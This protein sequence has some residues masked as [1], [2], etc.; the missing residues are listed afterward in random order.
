MYKRQ[1]QGHAHA[2]EFRHRGDLVIG[3]AVDAELVHVR[4]DHVRLE[5]IGEHGAGGL[6]RERAL[7]VADIEDDAALAGGEHLRL[8]RAL[9]SRCLLYTSRCV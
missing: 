9:R 4:R 8:H 5:A 7:A 3:R 2:E 6:E 1:V